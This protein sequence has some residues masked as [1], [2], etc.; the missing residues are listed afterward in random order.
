MNRTL[1]EAREDKIYKEYSEFL[2]RAGIKYDNRQY[3][4]Y[5]YVPLKNIKESFTQ[6][7]KRSSGQVLVTD[8]CGNCYTG[9]RLAKRV[10]KAIR[11]KCPEYQIEVEH[12]GASF[13]IEIY[14]NIELTSVEE[15][16]KQVL[17]VAQVVDIGVGIGKEMLGSDFVRS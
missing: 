7:C 9:V 16:H 14:H 12:Y 6:I 17:G 8:Y 5:V 13:E 11:E 3:D 15:L 10:A 1:D 2:D 4:F